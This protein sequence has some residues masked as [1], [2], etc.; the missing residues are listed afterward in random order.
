MMTL[1]EQLKA[2]K[3][4]TAGMMTP[5][6]TAA[7][8]Q[9]FEELAKRNVLDKT[10]KVGDT[11]PAFALPNSKGNVIGSQALLA[12]GPMVVLFYRGKW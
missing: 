2:I 7:M 1:Q 5:E 4:K 12:Q 9:G 11:A 8:K 6:I 3:A 10:L